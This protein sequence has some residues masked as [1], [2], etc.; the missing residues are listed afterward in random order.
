MP[1]EQKTV[2]LDELKGAVDE[3]MTTFSA[4]KEANDE[5]LAQIEEKGEADPVTVERMKK[6]DVSLLAFE[7]L[8][9]RFT[10]QVAGEKVRQEQMDDIQTALAR[11]GKAADREEQKGEKKDA[12]DAFLRKGDNNLSPE[13][14]KVLTIAD[15]TSGGYL[16]PSEYVAEIIKGIIEFSPMRALARVRQ[17]SQRSTMIPKRTGTFAASWVAELGSRSEAT[18]LAYGLAEVPNHDLRLR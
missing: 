11:I 5:R 16:A 3:V 8:N 18:G 15:D 2:T 6:I 13:Q 17:T 7:D 10:L 14:V 4:F 1:K 9:Q 12:F